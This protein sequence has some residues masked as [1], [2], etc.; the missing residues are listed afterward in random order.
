MSLLGSILGGIADAI[1]GSSITW[2]C[3]GCGVEMNGQPG[4]TTSSGWW[5]CT[6]CGY[7]NDVSPDNVYESEEDYEASREL[8]D[9]DYSGERLSVW[10]AADIWAS[11]GF[12]EDYTFGYSEEELKKAL[13]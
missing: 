13:K 5:T 2:Y 4:F 8:E 10:D 12:D 9:E 3:D 1:S 7:E 6:E 11:N